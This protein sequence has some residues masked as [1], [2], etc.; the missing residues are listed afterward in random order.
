M[1]IH[2][3]W[4]ILA[5]PAALAGSLADAADSDDI[6]AIDLPSQKQVAPAK[7]AKV[8]RRVEAKL[9]QASLKPQPGA[10]TSKCPISLSIKNVCDSNIRINVSSGLPEFGL[11]VIAQNE[12]V[13]MRTNKGELMFGEFSPRGI[14]C[15]FHILKPGDTA[16]WTFDLAELFALQPSVYSLDFSMRVYDTIGV[17]NET[18]RMQTVKI[19]SL[20]VAV[21]Q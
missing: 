1:R 15:I 2:Q 20:Q 4:F 6:S 8:S 18:M 12:R 19:E 11:K 3:L 21:G 9:I 17:K 7:P 5:A 16:E 10:T 14:Q 13:P